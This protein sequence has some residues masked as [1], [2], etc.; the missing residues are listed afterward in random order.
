M[1]V[2]Q[3]SHE[4]IH[5]SQGGLKLV[6]PGQISNKKYD[7]ELLSKVTKD[8]LTVQGIPEAYQ[9]LEMAVAQSD[10]PVGVAVE[11][12]TAPGA[13][14]PLHECGAGLRVAHV[15][16]ILP[17]EHRLDPDRF[18]A[19]PAAAQ[20]PPSVPLGAYPLPN[21][22]Y[23]NPAAVPSHMLPDAGEDSLDSDD[24]PL[25]PVP[26]KRK[27]AAGKKVARAVKGRPKAK[28]DPPPPG[29]FASPQAG[30]YVLT[31]DLYPEGP[32]FSVSQL[33]G[34]NQGTEADGCWGY[35]H[36]LSSVD[37]WK[38][39]ILRAKF[40]I[41]RGCIVDGGTELIHSYSIITSWKRG[42]NSSGKL[43]VA[44]QNII[45]QHPDWLVLQH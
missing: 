4:R 29:G 35:K 26:R 2:P 25:V 12:S 40:G 8:A 15:Q 3:I 34:D 7:K 32:G 14:G 31:H 6:K 16:L 13:L 24:A 42:L 21:V 17:S 5:V 30:T 33:V 20:P 38:K 41:G 27:R 28:R 19:L 23:T 45:K 11:S 44:I 39:S 1:V 36:L 10:I 18:W 37:P 43:P 9:W 22:R